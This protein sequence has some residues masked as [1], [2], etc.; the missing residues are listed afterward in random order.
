M[1]GWAFANSPSDFNAGNV[2]SPLVRGPALRVGAVIA[3][4]LMPGTGRAR[5]VEEIRHARA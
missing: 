2:N 3:R 1:I 5:E 4:H